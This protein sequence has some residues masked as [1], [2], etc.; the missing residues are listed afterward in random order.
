MQ[1]KSMKRKLIVRALPLL[2]FASLA[3][4]DELNLGPTQNPDTPYRLFNTQ[5]VYTLLKLDTAGG[6][7][8]LVQWG[9]KD[10]RFVAPINTNAL[11]TDGKPG[12][13]TLYPTKNVFTFILLDQ[14][15]GDAWHVQWGAPGERFI[16]HIDGTP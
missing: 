1:M 12:R 11:V 2:L 15:T 14:Q 13:F 9:D 16:V 5:N 4:A 8:W 6:R 10:H 3:L 7:I